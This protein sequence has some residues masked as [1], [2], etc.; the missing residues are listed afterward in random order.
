LNKK[1]AAF[2]LTLFLGST[3]LAAQ[4]IDRFMFPVTTGKLKNGLSVIL[5]E[6]DSLPVVTVAVAYR[7]GSIQDP[8]GKP[9][10]AYLMENLM[11][12]GS[13]DVPSREHFNF[14]TRVGG[15]LNASTSEEMTIFY[16]TVPSNQLALVLW[17][18]SDR[19]RF[20]D[21]NEA[22]FEQERKL[23]LDVV[24]QKRTSEPYAESQA[25]FDRMLYIDF[26]YSHPML[27]TEE[28]IR[29][30]TLEDVREFYATY[31][32]PNN[33]VLC[34]AGN[35]NKPKASELVAR[36]FETLP[37]GKDVNFAAEP[38]VYAKKQ[39]IQSTEDPQAL[40]PAAY[41]G[42]RVVPTAAKDLYTLKI[43]DYL[44]MR[45]RSSRLPRRLLSPDNKIAY[46][47]SGGIDQRGNRTAYQLF[48][49]ANNPYPYWIN[50]CQNAIFSELEKLKSAFPPEEE[51]AKAKAMFK[52]DYLSQ[53]ATSSDRA[54]YL[55]REF[56]TLRNFLDLPLELGNHWKVTATDVVTIA[57]RYFNTD[58]SVILN[59]RTK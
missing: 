9:G 28:D 12:R 57:H 4:T 31:Y 11:F 21:L 53:T 6:D 20:L 30:L 52:M 15:M 48:V 47:L 1:I 5:A 32:A 50:Q 14:I 33:A 18:E 26:P 37:R 39:D 23:L 44:L 35:F 55:C 10:L 8:S 29:N 19:M 56:F 51:I 41:M 49:I 43:L 38:F 17:L 27:G 16:Q 25:I 59:V 2:C 24:H 46:Q 58:N 34:I 13:Q 22:S 45:G 42:F 7:A 3:L 40:N 36:Y 54:I